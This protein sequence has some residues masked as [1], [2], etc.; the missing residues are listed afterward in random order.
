MRKPP[1]QINVRNLQRKIPINGAN[2]QQF[3]AIAMRCCL[4]LERRKRTELT[5]LTQVFVWLIS[6]R[7]MSQLHR[8]FL[9]QTG[10][11]DVLTFQHGEIFI[12]VEMAKRHAREFG[13]LLAREL[14]L[15]I[16]H[17]L[18]H[19]HGFDDRTPAGARKMKSTQEKIVRACSG[20][21]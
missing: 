9:G 17:G 1:P 18:L 16:V 7:R 5:K 4:Q 2:L 20:K 12:S 6:D 10:P 19:L 13:N 11:T 8:Q 15:Y 14:Q 21:R 3:A